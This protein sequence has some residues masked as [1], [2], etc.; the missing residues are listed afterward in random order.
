MTSKPA[1]M[2]S[3]IVWINTSQ[4]C[5]KSPMREALLLAAK[6]NLPLNYNKLFWKRLN[7]IKVYDSKMRKGI[8]SPTVKTLTQ[9]IMILNHPST[10]EVRMEAQICIEPSIHKVASYSHQQTSP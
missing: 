2:I 5:R 10:E 6:L 1:I 4:K 3:L 9:L 7:R 8:H